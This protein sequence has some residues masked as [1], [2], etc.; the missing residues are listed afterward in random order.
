MNH[1]QDLIKVEA[2]NLAQTLSYS[3]NL[4][5]YRGA[6]LKLRDIM[7]KLNHAFNTTLALEPISL[8]ASVGLF[9]CADSQ[10][11][12]NVITDYL[13]RE[14]PGYT[15]VVNGLAREEYQD[16]NNAKEVLIQ[17]GRMAQLQQSSVSLCATVPACAEQPICRQ[18]HLLCADAQQYIQADKQEINSV[19]AEQF[20]F[21]RE[22]KQ[23]FYNNE[24]AIINKHHRELQFTHNIEELCSNTHVS[25]LDNKV[26]Y[27]YFDGNKFSA[28]QQKVV[29]S[30]TSQKAFDDTLQKLR[31]QLLDD[32]LQWADTEPHFKT[33]DPKPKIRL[34]TLLW[35]GDECL[36]VMSAATGF[37]FIQ[38]IMAWTQTWQYQNY[39]LTH[40]FGLVF[41]QKGSPVQHM[42]QVAETLA[43][44]GKQQLIDNAKPVKGIKGIG[45]CFHYL[46]FESVD[47][48]TTDLPQYFTACY[49]ALA[50]QRQ[51]ICPQA[52]NSQALYQLSDLLS[53]LSKS[54]LY[55]LAKAVF[56][57]APQQSD[58]STMAAMEQ[59]LVIVT[60]MTLTQVERLVAVAGEVLLG[61]TLDLSSTYQPQRALLW[62]LL[63]ECR[64]YLVLT[65]KEEG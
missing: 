15:F 31:A 37:A 28:I 58:F 55:Q 63:C 17:Q 5:I 22:Q 6:S 9:S 26:A 59:R 62:V 42:R 12:V 40:C 29:D 30:I 20:R 56:L 52:F 7:F 36:F 57:E 33:L 2:V 13:D 46:I 49:G 44:H 32:I 35:G 50:Q 8:G 16:F 18:S 3:D 64:P 61:Q 65:N 48:L 54:A 39:P 27:V 14:M 4:S 51:A 47:A 41:C 19:L 1:A 53:D 34:E 21:G 10:V 23:Q 24:L 25:H 45:N 11:A 38:K 43:Q 60:N